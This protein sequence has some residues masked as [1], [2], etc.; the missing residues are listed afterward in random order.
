MSSTK[1][2]EMSV[3]SDATRPCTHLQD[4]IVKPK[5]FIDGTIQY[6]R[7]GLLMTREPYTCMKH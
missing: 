5:V 7:L 4:N 6:D 3:Q 2:L 1:V